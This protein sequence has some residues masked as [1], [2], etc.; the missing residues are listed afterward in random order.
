[1]QNEIFGTS[2][3]DEGRWQ[4]IQLYKKVK[5]IFIGSIIWSV[6]NVLS[7]VIRLT[8]L[9]QLFS[10]GKNTSQLIVVYTIW[11]L[12]IILFPLQGYY[13]YAFSKEMKLSID[14]QNVEKFNGGF[15]L[16]N[17][18]ATLVLLSLFMNFLSILYN[19]L[20]PYLH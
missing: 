1:M 11:V 7:I 6:I 13:Y 3:N 5:I 2:L 16:L 17:I 4:L 9:K 18:N 10:Y 8:A 14:V 12:T 19:V 20:S 15:R